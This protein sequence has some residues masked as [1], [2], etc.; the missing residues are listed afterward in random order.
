[1][2]QRHCFFGA[3]VIVGWVALGE[4]VHG[5]SGPVG[6]ENTGL[7]ACEVD[8]P[9]WFN[10]MGEGLGEVFDGLSRG[11]VDVEYWDSVRV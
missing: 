5:A 3:H 9:F 10:F 6:A 11:V 7:D 1:M 4:E 8:V 2:P